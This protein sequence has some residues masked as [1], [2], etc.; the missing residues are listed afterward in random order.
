MAPETAV[1]QFKVVRL[2]GR[3]GM[4]EVYLARDLSLGR[5]VA[6]KLIRRK[7]IGSEKALERFLYEA[8]VT[9]RFSHP[10]IV[11]VYSV[12]EFQGSPYVALEYLEGQTLR[13]RMQEQLS[14][15]QCIR[16]GLAIAEALE[17]AHSGKILHRDLK[18]DNVLIPKDGRLRVVDFGLAQPIDA[19]E[20]PIPANSDIDQ[21]S[22][23]DT[24]VEETALSR[25]E[26]SGG[27]GVTGTP[28]Y[29]SP[30]Q[31]L[32]H[33]CTAATDV[34]AWGLVMYEMLSGRRAYLEDTV[35]QLCLKVCSLE[36]TPALES[37]MDVPE[38]LQQ[39]VEQCIEKIPERRPTAA[40]IVSTL[41][42]LLHESRGH[43]LDRSSP[44]KGLMAFSEQDAAMFFGRDQEIVAFLERM[45]EIPVLPVVGPSG[46]GKSSFVMAGIVPRLRE[47]GPW[48][49]L[50]VK[51]GPR[52]F[53]TL[54]SRLLAGEAS[55]TGSAS[56]R[57]AT[58]RS[59][60]AAGEKTG[61]PGQ[62]DPAAAGA[63]RDELAAQLE[64]SPARLAMLL[65]DHA[66]DTGTRVLLVV[67][68]AEE[69]Y[70]LVEDEV[71]RRSFMQ[72]VCCGADDPMGAVR[73][74]FTV[75]DDFLGKVAESPEAR[76]ALSR[77]TVVR[78]PGRGALEEILVRPVEALGFSFD[79]A[80]LVKDMVAE[81]T[82]EAAPLPLLQF[83]AQILWER[84][85]R[86][87]QL[88]TRGAY[89]EIGG[90]AGALARHAD[91]MLEG[92]TAEQVHVA[93]EILLRLVTPQ[94]TRKIQSQAQLVEGLPEEAA[95]I[96]GRLVESRILVVRRGRK[97]KHAEL[98]LVHESIIR[99][100]GTLARWLDESREEL[101]FLADVTQAAELWEKHGASHDEV[102]QADA[103]RDA[104]KKLEQCST[105]IPGLVSRFIE[106]GLKLEKRRRKRRRLTLVFSGLALFL[107]AVV[108][109]V[110]SIVFKEQKEEAHR[111][112]QLAREQKQEAL[113]EGAKGAYARNQILEARAHVR[114][115]FEG[116]DTP[117]ARMLW[118]QLKS[119]P[120][121]WKRDFGAVVY[122]VAYS[123]D[124]RWIAVASGDKAVYLLNTK[125]AAA[126]VLRGHSDQVEC[127]N[128]DSTG[129]QLASGTWNGE[130]AI[131]DVASGT[132]SHVSAHSSSVY[133]V[134]F[135][136]DGARL[137]TAGKDGTVRQWDLATGTPVGEPIQ[138][139]CAV[140]TVTF[141]PD[142]QSLLTGAR[143]GTIRTYDTFSGDHKSS[144]KVHQ[145]DI[146]DLRFQPGT[147]IL[148]SAGSDSRIILWDSRTW[149]PIHVLSGH[150]QPVRGLGFSPD[151]KM[152]ASGSADQTV[153]LW[154]TV[155][156]EMLGVLGEEL[157]SIRNV[158]FGPQGN[159]LVSGTFG[160]T[161]RTWK[162]GRK[163]VQ[164][165]VGGHS[166]SV[167]ALAYSP[168]GNLI[169]TGS[170]DSTIRIW[171]AESGRL[172]RVLNQQKG[173]VSTIAFSGDGLKMVAGCYGD[174]VYVWDTNTWE[175][176]T[177]F[178]RHTG[179]I[180]GVDIHPNGQWVASGGYD[181]V[182]RIWDLE[183]GQ[184][185]R[186][187]SGHKS[188]VMGVDI[189]P[190]GRLIAAAGR[191][192]SIHVWLADSGA[193]YA[194]LQG[195][196]GGVFGVRFSP[197]SKHLISGGADRTLRMW[198]LD[199]RKS[200]VLGT[201]GGRVYW[202][203]FSPDGMKVGAP[204]SDGTVTQFTVTGEVSLKIAGH[205][206]EANALLY[207]PDGS[208]L[209]TVGDD[210]T[211]RTGDAQSG[212]PLWRAALIAPS[213]PCLWSH[214]G[215]VTADGAACEGKGAVGPR[216]AEAIQ[217]RASKAA[218][219]DDKSI[220]CLRGFAAQLEVWNAKSDEMLFRENLTGLSDVLAFGQGCV[221]VANSQ[222]RLYHGDST[223]KD[224]R[225]EA[226]AVALHRGQLLVAAREQ[227]FQFADGSTQLPLTDSGPGVT[228]LARTGPWVV[229]GFGDG[230]IELAPTIPGAPRPSFSFQNVPSS[231][232]M[233]LLPGPMNTLVAGYANGF[234][235]LWSLADGSLMRSSRLH[236]PVTYL[237]IRDATA[238]LAS[239]LGDMDTWDLTVLHRDYCTVMDEIWSDVPVVWHNGQPVLRDPPEDHPCRQ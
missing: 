137:A 206:G 87:E 26:D 91:G 133:D 72:A 204:A 89:K 165:H 210:G 96:L 58:V 222:V 53:Q 85:D 116:A 117:L 163:S 35:Q 102:W 226:I 231:Q 228:A 71:T 63:A 10:H 80:S 68:Q 114:M 147:S 3:G 29:M 86:T 4:G 215:V 129:R 32:R 78:S 6:L 125:T 138:H 40:R 123:P 143:D 22:V 88:L 173:T 196:E 17:E 136:P 37:L 118:W 180:S 42:G 66:R 21:L 176:T 172:E 185:M 229:L 224:L 193:E 95:E 236:G 145:A 111:Q 214:S 1:D 25:P 151:G 7:A 159:Q 149:D 61:P 101:D 217:Q 219:S 36:R 131:W 153:R 54:A 162:I 82:N 34:W 44:F 154:D 50:H 45:R 198:N 52:P 126:R 15:A 30:E 181:K 179:S 55:L 14:A 144:R 152:L 49:V 211:L 209:A 41:S 170:I 167:Y 64:E 155:S 79:D 233:K 119:N 124:G 47:Q 76:E 199:S 128:F 177:E 216:L 213:R 127:V 65:Q 195:H 92:L 187:L 69:L 134:R 120:L 106:T 70:T 11:T 113:A 33:D 221:T 183:T 156:G 208:S 168:D 90:V 83:A 201:L 189:S 166:D 182:V 74:I 46:A 148:A 121:L 59:R 232:V 67:D 230:N 205:R 141:S 12:G 186:V 62:D 73:V 77:V 20:I 178:T 39:I 115:L 130:I 13:M 5:L 175:R 132:A 2:L 237:A 188:A 60:G 104:V 192:K 235:G 184:Q 191:D 200:L 218:F 150:Q 103:L 107:F 227:V 75:R 51:P 109:L 212:K 171:Q 142:G 197:D 98:E 28:A 190:D 234:V 93:R 81:V 135:S 220:A 100:W 112:M 223:Y 16:I 161:V 31:W 164:Q 225:S 174:G 18:P 146:A 158:A 160:R 43:R 105:S 57:L 99:T 23:A 207:S 27:V 8:R 94:R 9:A 56:S 203:D 140:L 122:D 24:M 239:E 48:T 194:T 238:Y 169:A 97:S 157:G 19:P 139:P 202:P 84:R 110:F 38:E 108:S